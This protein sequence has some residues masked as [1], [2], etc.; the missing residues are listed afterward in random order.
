MSPLA[1]LRKSSAIR[2]LSCRID[3]DVSYKLKMAVKERRAR[4][5]ERVKPDGMDSMKLSRKFT[6]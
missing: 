1:S 4:E 5:Q 6:V 2:G 3:R